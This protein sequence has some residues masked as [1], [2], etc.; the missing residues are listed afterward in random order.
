MGPEFESPAGHQKEPSPFGD[1]SFWLP[2]QRFEGS[3]AVRMSTAAASS[4]AANLNFAVRQNA[5]ESPAGSDGSAASGRGSDLSE[6][7]RSVSDAGVR[8]KESTG[9]RNRG[10][11]L[12]LP[13]GKMQTNLEAGHLYYY[14]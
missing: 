12:I 1:G 8:A 4:M 2:P 13:L 10:R 14:V 6:W 3:N 5:N 11:T 9:H 7:L